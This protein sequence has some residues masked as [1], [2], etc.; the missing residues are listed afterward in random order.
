MERLCRI[1]T[2]LNDP[3]LVASVQ[4][5]CGIRIDGRRRTT[6]NGSV[7]GRLQSRDPETQPNNHSE[8]DHELPD[9]EAS[10]AI[11][12][13]SMTNNVQ[14][15][16]TR[17]WLYYLA[18]FGAFL[19]NE[20]FNCCFF[21]F[22][23]WN[24]DGYIARRVV[25]LWAFTLYVGQ[26][27]KDIVCWPR[28]RSPPAAKLEQRYEL[29]YGMP[30]THAMVG[31]LMPFSILWMT[32][33]RY[34]YNWWLGLMVCIVWMTVVSF[35]RVYLG[36]H[37]V[38]DVLV[39]LSLGAVLLLLLPLLDTIDDFQLSAS[40]IAPV[41][42]VLVPLAMAFIYPTVHVWSTARGDTTMILAC[43][44]GLSLA[45]WLAVQHKCYTNPMPSPPYPVRLPDLWLL[46]SSLL[47]M[48]LGGFVLVATRFMAKLCSYRVLCWTQGVQHKDARAIQRLSIELP[49]KFLT[50]TAVAFN[51]A[52]LCPLVFKF[53]GIHK[54]TDYIEP[55]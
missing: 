13:S 39:G 29:E 18:I 32:S 52:Y 33:D 24:V 48:A 35:S 8:S 45:S 31:L 42:M 50:Y 14:F 36:M 10:K 28:P 1:G 23:L 7:N 49:H 5:F 22:W 16:I 4:D 51:V 25:L 46:L 55:Y 27:I 17:P 53:V 43:S 47:R 54:I 34:E 40:V 38:L 19:G 20:S 44:A 12:K 30:S 15:S 21:P 37:S 11:L 3:A 6:S 9:H 26:C 2:Y 41:V